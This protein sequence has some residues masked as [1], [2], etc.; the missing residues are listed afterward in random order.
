MALKDFMVKSNVQMMGHQT[1]GGYLAG[2]TNFIIDPDGTI[3]GEFTNGQVDKL[4]KVAVAQWYDP[5]GL[6]LVAP[7]VYETTA[8]T[9]EPTIGKPEDLNTEIE[10]GSLE[11]SNV[12]LAD[13]FTKLIEAQRAFQAASKMISTLDE[14]SPAAPMS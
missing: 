12:D 5:S 1:V 8:A 13:Q 11:V 3:N 9:G 14:V 7:S 10:S 6:S 4:A 2:P